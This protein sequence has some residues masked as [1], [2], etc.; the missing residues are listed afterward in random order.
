MGEEVY[1]GYSILLCVGCIIGALAGLLVFI[2]RFQN[3]FEQNS[4]YRN[5]IRIILMIMIFLVVF[6]SLTWLNIVLTKMNCWQGG[7]SYCDTYIDYE[8][9]L[10]AEHFPNEIMIQTMLPVFLRDDFCFSE[11]QIVCDIV[12]EY[13]SNL[14]IQREYIV[15][16]ISTLIAL[17][18]LNLSIE[19]F[20]SGDKKKRNSLT[21]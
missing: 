21:K 16:I 4:Q 19:Y 20:T 11:H 15:L 2:P 1:I 5:S 9:P 7:S 18:S 3:V 10:L 6:P 13:T 12:A 14:D 17:L 8:N